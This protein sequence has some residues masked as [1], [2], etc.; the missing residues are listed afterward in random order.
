V[1]APASTWRV[2]DALPALRLPPLTQGTLERYA[3]ASGDHAA[4]HL[5]ASYARTMG[6]PGVI[7]HGL[8]VMAYLGRMLTGWQEASR[9]RSFSCRFVAVALLGDCLECTG[10]VAAVREEGGQRLA[11]LE[12]AVRDQHAALKLSGRATVRL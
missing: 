7:A 10:V 2:G 4:V 11:D 3:Q 1:S 6:F 9:L 12:L 8:L 5:D